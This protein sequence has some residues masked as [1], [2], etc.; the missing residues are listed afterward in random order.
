V[1]VIH[2]LPQLFSNA[3]N[4]GAKMTTKPELKKATI[5]SRIKR[6]MTPEEAENTPLLRKRHNKIPMENVLKIEEEGLSISSSAYVLGVPVGSLYHF[7]QQHNINW[8]GKRASFYKGE[9]DYNS[10][11][12]KSI[13]LGLH[14]MTIHK[15]MER[16]QCSYDEAVVIGNRKFTR[17]TK[18]LIL[19]A[20]ELKSSGL[21]L[22][23]TAKQLNCDAQWL[24]KKIKEFLKNE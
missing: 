13:A 12:Q 2:P 21:T 4:E 10:N 18:E 17:I 14:N 24:G 16:L 20:I 15:R 3:L 6:G 9:K 22:K 5:L 7:I 8:R 19:K 11:L 23:D 1:G